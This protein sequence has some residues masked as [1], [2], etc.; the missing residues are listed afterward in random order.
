MYFQVP[1][2]LQERE[3]QAAQWVCVD[4]MTAF[5]KPKPG[6]IWD[7][8]YGKIVPAMVD[9]PTE[10]IR[11]ISVPAGFRPGNQLLF[12]PASFRGEKEGKPKKGL[13]YME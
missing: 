9:S 12:M 6:S 1:L 2:I 7:E 4:E 3:V 10:G 13:K 8:V 5:V 11:V